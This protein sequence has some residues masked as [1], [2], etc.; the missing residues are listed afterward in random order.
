M[1]LALTLLIA[2]IAL[3]LTGEPI[4]TVILV[5]HAEKASSDEDPP[6]SAAGTARAAELARVLSAT[7]IDTIY[8]TQYVRTKDT[9]APVAKALGV[10]AQVFPAGKGYAAAIAAK[11]R[12][13]HQGQTVLVAGHSNSTSDVA[14]ALGAENVPKIDESQYDYLFIVTLSGED[15]SL[16][17]LRYGPPT[18]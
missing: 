2:V 10:Q 16:V 15:E 13:H 6:L 11:I 3:P 18:P 8:T 14:R 12:D 7:R 9:A 1:R 5:R 4:T 17:V